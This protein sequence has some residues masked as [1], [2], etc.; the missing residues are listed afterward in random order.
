VGVG[1]EANGNIKSK[2]LVRLGLTVDGGGLGSE[3]ELLVGHAALNLEGPGVV[4]RVRAMVL[5]EESSFISGGIEAISRESLLLRNADDDGLAVHSIDSL[6]VVVLIEVDKD[7]SPGSSRA[8]HGVAVAI[9][10]S[11][12]IIANRLLLLTAI[13]VRSIS[14]GI[15]SHQSNLALL[16]GNGSPSVRVT[17][18]HTLLAGVSSVSIL[19]NWVVTKS[20]SNNTAIGDS[21]G[22]SWGSRLS[23]GI[24]R[25][26][27]VRIA[28][29][30]ALRAVT[31]VALSGVTI[32]GSVKVSLNRRL[33]GSTESESSDSEVVHH[34]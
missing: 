8:S 10:I 23:R 11:R 9:V 1:I 25:A 27:S 15:A 3:V 30:H 22:V 19:N 29:K 18:K 24:L 31:K 34:F 6:H 26:P 2:L 16:V 5:K 28:S 32:S 17:A 7:W 21:S 4:I 12:L 33:G 20:T 13:R 14:V